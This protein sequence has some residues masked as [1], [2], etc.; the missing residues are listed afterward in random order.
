MVQPRPAQSLRAEEAQVSSERCGHR[1][2]ISNRRS[3]RFGDDRHPNEMGIVAARLLA[4]YWKQPHDHATVAIY[5]F[6]ANAAMLSQPALEL[7]DPSVAGPSRSLRLAWH[8]AAFN[9]ELHKSAHPVYVLA[10]D[11]LRSASAQTPT[12]MLRKAIDDGIVDIRDRNVG[13]HKPLSKVAG[14]AMEAG[15]RQLCVSQST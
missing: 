1:L 13:E 8:G 7:S 4:K 12:A 2:Y 15:H 3:L 11:A 10:G 5:C 6:L 9:E 14:G